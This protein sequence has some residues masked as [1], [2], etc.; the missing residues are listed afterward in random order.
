MLKEKSLQELDIESLDCDEPSSFENGEVRCAQCD[1]EISDTASIF[2]LDGH[3]ARNVFA[4]PAGHLR[5]VITFNAARNYVEDLQQIKDF[6]WFAGYSG[7]SFIASI[8]SPTLDGN[9][10]VMI[11]EH[12]IC[13]MDY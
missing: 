12:R 2:S 7:K 1:Q 3:S 4:N 10:A 13:F 5:V 11:A 6:T 9:I 8:A